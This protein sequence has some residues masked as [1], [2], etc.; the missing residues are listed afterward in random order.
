M[1]L[2]EFTEKVRKE[3]NKIEEK[4]RRE[5]NKQITEKFE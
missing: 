3:Q 5:A 4:W 2:A 1:N